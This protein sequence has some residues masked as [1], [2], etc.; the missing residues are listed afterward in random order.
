MDLS[1]LNDLETHSEDEATPM[2]PHAQQV[3]TINDLEVHSEDEA[4]LAQPHAP[5]THRKPAEHVVDES[6]LVEG[7]DWCTISSSD[8]QE[9][10]SEESADE[11]VSHAGY[12]STSS[13]NFHVSDVIRFS[14][15][16]QHPSSNQGSYV[17]DREQYRTRFEAWSCACQR[18]CGKRCSNVVIPLSC[19]G[20][21]HVR[22]TRMARMG[23]GAAKLVFRE[24]SMT[25]LQHL[26]NSNRLGR[27]GSR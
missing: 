23:M 26:R 25:I 8:A 6:G 24:A 22:T 3:P 18:E 1:L 4:L 11:R 17:L 7:T 9:E 20:H 16:G 19:H 15:P 13:S 14:W 10:S 27:N 12:G 2:L 5:P 21:T